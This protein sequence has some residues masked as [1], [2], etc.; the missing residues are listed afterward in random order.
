[1]TDT[2]TRAATGGPSGI[3]SGSPADAREDAREIARASGLRYT[4]DTR[5][6]FTRHRTGRGF[7][8][9]DRDGNTIRDKEVLERIRRIVIPPA[10]TDVWI[11]PW[12]NGHLQATGRDARGRKQYLYH[13]QYGFFNY[14]LSWFSIG[15]VNWLSDPKWAMPSIILMAVWKRSQALSR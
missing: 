10:W 15:P 11:S 7:T 9:R 5:P 3:P 8:Y 4:T 14:I 12:P 2:S 6:G 1:M 13:P